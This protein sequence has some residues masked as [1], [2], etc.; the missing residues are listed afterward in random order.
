[1]APKVSIITIN[2][3]NVSGLK[4]T[5]DS[6]VQQTYKGI[7]FIV[8]DGA[9]TDGSVDTLFQQKKHIHV[10]ISEKDSGIYN[11]MNKG[12]KKAKGDYLLFLNSGDILTGP[13][14]I[15]DFVNHPHF[16]GDIIYGDYK[17]EQ[18]QKMYPEL[19]PPHYF[20]KTSLPHQSTFF[21]K[22]VFEIMGL[23]DETYKM[24]ADRAYFI[25]CFENKEITFQ[26]IDYFLTLFD[27]SGVSNDPKYLAN[28]KTE[29]ER[30]LYEFY[31]SKYEDYKVAVQ[32]EAKRKKAE[33]NSL[34][35]ILKRIINRIKKI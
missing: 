30:M 27:L 8:I 25:K 18:G 26:H 1:M 6:V 15:E 32:L 23:Y 12:I 22:S 9:S 4:K 29:D 34:K 11:A 20:M 19:L 33:R 28:K 2:Y 3:N 24:G 13:T 14:A 17:F 31:G 10:I 7:E 35:G 16:G 21:K 5:I